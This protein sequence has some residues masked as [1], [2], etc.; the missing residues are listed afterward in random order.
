MRVGDI[1][2]ELTDLK[3]RG[4]P[5]LDAEPRMGF[6]GHRIALLDPKAAGIT[7]EWWRTRGGLR[8][9]CYSPLPVMNGLK[10]CFA[11]SVSEAS[12]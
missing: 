4:I 9:P 7:L 3:S 2:K 10:S 11:V 6:A 8:A 5:L 1:M 12:T